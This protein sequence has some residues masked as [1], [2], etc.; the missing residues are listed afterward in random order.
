LVAGA[1]ARLIVLGLGRAGG[2]EAEAAPLDLDLLTRGYPSAVSFRPSVGED[3]GPVAY[4]QWEKRLL[5]LGGIVGKVLNEA[6]DYTGKNN[7]SYF[8][9][10]KQRNPSKLLMLHYIGTGRRATDEATTKSFQATSSTTRAP[11]SPKG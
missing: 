6:H 4:E 2:R 8:V 9:N 10:Y 7:L 3:P 1:G 5:P 11:N